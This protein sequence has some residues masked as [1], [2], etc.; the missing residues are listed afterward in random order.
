[1]K[2]AMEHG[3]EI[4]EIYDEDKWVKPLIVSKEIYE[5]S[6]KVWDKSSNQWVDKKK[7]KNKS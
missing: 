5:L 7:G 3:K 4:V 2:H 6:N 1:M